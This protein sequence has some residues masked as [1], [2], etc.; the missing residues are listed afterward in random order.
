MLC[1]DYQH[2]IGACRHRECAPILIGNV[3]RRRIR[4]TRRRGHGRG[5]QQ[6]Q[7]VK[8]PSWIGDRAVAPAPET[9]KRVS[10]SSGRCCEGGAEQRDVRSKVEL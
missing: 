7:L 3:N 10:T 5:T 2:G 4:R 6:H 1:A 8:K 9:A